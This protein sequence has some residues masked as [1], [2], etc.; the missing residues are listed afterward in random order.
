MKRSR[1]IGSLHELARFE[2]RSASRQLADA[3]RE[4]EAEE[5]QLAQLNSFR[6]EYGRLETV[7]TGGTDP[8]RLQNY[9]AFMDRLSEAIRQQE[10][11]LESAR[12]ALAGSTETWRGRRIDA[13]ALAAAIERFS[14]DERR[15]VVRREQRDSDEVAQRVILADPKP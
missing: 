6:E 13:E 10:K 4:L 14:A 9:R 3:A 8:L 7:T 11:R 1:R 12:A 5:R 15:S 2:E